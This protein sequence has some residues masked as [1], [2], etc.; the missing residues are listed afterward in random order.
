MTAPSDH[1]LLRNGLV[2]AR[3]EARSRL[4]GMLSWCET[5]LVGDYRAT[6]GLS[7]YRILT[8]TA[9]LGLL[10]A[11]FAH[12]HYVWGR[13]ARWQVLWTNND[14]YGWP[15]TWVFGTADSSTVFTIKYLVMIGLA[16]AVILGWRTRLAMPLLILGWAS[17]ERLGPLTRDGGDN[18]LRIIGFYACFAN[19]GEHWSLDARRRARRGASAL[20]RRVPRWLPVVFSNVA[21]VVMACQ[22]FLIYLVSGLLK[23]QSDAWQSG[24]AMYFPLHGDRYMVW[25]ALS[26]A[27]TRFA[28]VVVFVTYASVFIQVFFPLMLIRRGTRVIGLIAITSMHAGIGI[29]LGLPWF[30]MS[31]VA[32]DMIFIRDSTFRS[33]RRRWQEVSALARR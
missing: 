21:L 12:R 26:S 25:P 24:T 14:G 27:T 19:L 32:A 29:M 7:L 17:L 16:V 9:L 5:W 33:A 13:G 15:F 4:R 23:V 6:H 8:G 1:G 2:A 20:S 22:V 31:M 30:S 28:I 3:A 10:L 11:N 18:V